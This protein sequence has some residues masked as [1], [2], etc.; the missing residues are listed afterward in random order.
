MEEALAV[1]QQLG[2][3]TVLQPYRAQ[4]LAKDGRILEVWMT[5]T[6]LVNEAGETYALA[7]TERVAD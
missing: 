6:A 2:R 7:T 5:T 3:G 4:R 1:V